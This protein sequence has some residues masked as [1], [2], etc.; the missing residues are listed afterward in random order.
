MHVYDCICILYIIYI[1]YAYVYVHIRLYNIYIY[2]IVYTIITHIYIYTS[3]HMHTFHRHIWSYMYN[4]YME[5]TSHTHNCIIYSRLYN[6]IWIACEK[7]AWTGAYN[8]QREAFSYIFAVDPMHRSLIFMGSI[9]VLLL[10]LVTL[11]IGCS[12]NLSAQS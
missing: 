3:I 12:R 8:G 1:W 4:I 2:I 10:Q 9:C 5:H 7:Q 11:Q 6:E